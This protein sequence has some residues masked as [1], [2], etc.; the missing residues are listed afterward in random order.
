MPFKSVRDWER[1]EPFVRR[2]GGRFHKGPP[3]KEKINAALYKL[4]VQQNRLEGAGMRM[5]QHDRELFNKCTSAQLSKDHARATMYANECAEIRKMAKVTMQCQLALEQVSIR[6]ETIEEFGDM[7][8]MMGPVAGVIQSIK[9][10]VSGLMPEVSYEL[11]E[12]GEALN[13]V[14]VEVGEATGQVYDSEA[15]SDEARNILTEAGTVAEQRM[16]DKFPEIPAA[17]RLEERAQEPTFR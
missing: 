8:A 9:G 17:A 10:Q 1:R 16:R 15:S 14:V 4:K 12:I 5:Q 11:G 2:L 3:I 13:G 6:L 7:A